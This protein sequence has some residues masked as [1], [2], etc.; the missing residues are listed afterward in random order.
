MELLVVVLIGEPTYDSTVGNNNYYVVA[1]GTTYLGRCILNCT[2][3]LIRSANVFSSF[4]H[5]PTSAS[6][7]APTLYLHPRK[8]WGIWLRL[9][10]ISYSWLAMMGYGK[11]P[12]VLIK[13]MFTD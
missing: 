11:H 1:G 12:V 4:I 6:A 9:A 7:S 13:H 8:A 2:F 3:F 10:L 5:L